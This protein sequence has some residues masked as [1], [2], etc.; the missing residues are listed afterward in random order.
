MADSLLLTLIR[1]GKAEKDSLSGKDEDRQLKPRGVKQ[2]HFL[3]ETLAA[4]PAERR[5]EIIL[6]SPVTRA[7]ETAR[8][9]AQ[10]SRIPLRFHHQISTSSNHHDV[11]EL[12]LDQLAG[13]RHRRVAIVGHNPTLEDLVHTL[14]RDSRGGIRCAENVHFD[15]MHTGMAAVLSFGEPSDITDKTVAK[16]TPIGLGFAPGKGT[17]LMCLREDWDDE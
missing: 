9:I 5:P 11:M 16:S 7:A 3:G 6:A 15:A 13:D 1:H 4:L 14:C 12:L 17:L 10:L 2:A 8:I